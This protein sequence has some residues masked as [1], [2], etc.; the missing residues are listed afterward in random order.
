MPA[1]VSGWKDSAPGVP[2]SNVAELSERSL[3]AGDDCPIATHLSLTRIDLSLSAY[4][5]LPHWTCCV[6]RSIE[7]RSCT[8]VDI[9]CPCAHRSHRIAIA[10]HRQRSQRQQ[11]QL[12]TVRVRTEQR[13]PACQR[14]R[15][16]RKRRRD[17]GRAHLVN[18]S[19]LQP[20][21]QC[22]PAGLTGAHQAVTRGNAE[23]R[24]A[25]HRWRED[26]GGAWLRR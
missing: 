1:D 9:C 18:V 23:A 13:H 21:R 22:C 7:G 3:V 19:R 15:R 5:G 17:R 25:M 26:S 16:R 11:G 2:S 14:P 4:R 8:T 24:S 20:C 10:T 6:P 12:S